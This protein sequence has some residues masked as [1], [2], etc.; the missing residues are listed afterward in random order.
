MARAGAWKVAPARAPPTAASAASSRSSSSASPRASRLEQR[1]QRPARRTTRVSGSAPGCS[2]HERAHPCLEQRLAVRPQPAAAVRAAG[3]RPGASRARFSPAVQ[4]GDAA[5]QRAATRRRVKPASSMSRPKAAGSREARHRGGQVRVG[6]AVAA[7]EAADP[8]QHAAE[9]QA[10]ERA[11]QARAAWRTRGPPAVRPAAARGGSRRRAARG[12]PTLRMPKRDERAVEAAASRRGSRSRVAGGQGRSAR[13]ARGA[14]SLR[15]AAREHLAREVD[16]H[17][18]WPRVAAEDLDRAGRRCPCR[19]RARARP[20]RRPSASTAGA[21]PAQV[22]ARGEQPV[23]Q[24]VARRDAVEHR[25]HRRLLGGAGRGDAAGHRH[26]P[27]SRHGARII[28][29]ARPAA[30]PA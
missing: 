22:D 20:A 8:R 6:R 9:V 28:A 16:A 1:V 15:G 7:H 5:G 25:A 29:H 18:A 4:V 12:S 2:R 26:R 30:R 13:R 17:A 23:Q 27:R 14:R 10:V 19:G 11:Q 3:R 21:P 24:V